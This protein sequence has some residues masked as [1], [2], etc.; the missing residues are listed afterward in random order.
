MIIQLVFN[1]FP[2]YLS[3]LPS[4]PTLFSSIAHSLYLSY[5]PF[6]VF[7]TVTINKRQLKSSMFTNKTCEISIGSISIYYYIMR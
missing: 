3:L 6:A 4:K 5:L 1:F 7:S 2:S